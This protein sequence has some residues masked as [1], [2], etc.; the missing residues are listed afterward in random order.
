[1]KR[2]IALF[3]LIALCAFTAPAETTNIQ[4]S[5]FDFVSHTNLYV[6]VAFLY[7]LE[8][9]EPGAAVGLAYKLD[10][11]LLQDALMPEVRLDCMRR[12]LWYI[13]GT[14]TL[15]PPTRW[16][17][18]PVYPIAEAGIMSSFAGGGTDNGSAVP[19]TGL[20]I[21]FNISGRWG[22]MLGY[23]WRFYS[24]KTHDNIAAALTF[25]F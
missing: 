22:G 4:S 20:G 24:E 16:L 13:E 18:T 19:I 15:R 10:L 3:G 12:R 2:I 17:N 8:D 9:H 14:L 5:I 21:A 11:P 7:D 25:R 1:M 23:E 6:G